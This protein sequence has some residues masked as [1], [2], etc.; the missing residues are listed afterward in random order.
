MKTFEKII[1]FILI[2]A[3]VV[4]AAPA[5]IMMCLYVIDKISVQFVEW[6]FYNYSFFEFL[7]TMIVEGGLG[8]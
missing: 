5:I 4:I 2:G 7:R 6:E 1:L 3:Y 8:L